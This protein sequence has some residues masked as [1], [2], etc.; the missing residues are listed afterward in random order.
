MTDQLKCL[1]NDAPIYFQFKKKHLSTSTFEPVLNSDQ[2]YL[3]FFIL[4]VYILMK[5]KR[6]M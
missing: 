3:K 5:K 2:I 1:T 4:L 6:A